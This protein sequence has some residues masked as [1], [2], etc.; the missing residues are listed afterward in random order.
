MFC[1]SPVWKAGGQLDVAG[2]DIPACQL[3]AMW[4]D[5][6]LEGAEGATDWMLLRDREGLLG[7]VA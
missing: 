2:A 4:C 6:P 1:R 5:A 7:G 3:V